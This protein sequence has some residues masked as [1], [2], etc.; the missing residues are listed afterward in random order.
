M[1]KFFVILCIIAITITEAKAYYDLSTPVEGKSLCNDTLQFNI[2]KYLY[3]KLSKK[4]P[5]C[6]DYKIKTTELIHYPYDLKKDKNGRYIKGYWQE[7]WTV[8]YCGEKLQIPISFYI[9]KG[10]TEFDVDD[11]FVN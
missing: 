2:M 1:K 8:N 3:K 10:N 7:L 9:K 5:A 11:D 4:Y 6:S